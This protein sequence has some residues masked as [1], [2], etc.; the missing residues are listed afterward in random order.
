VTAAAA[1]CAVVLVRGDVG[2]SP[3]ALARLPAGSTLSA[4]LALALVVVLPGALAVVAGW[5]RSQ[6]TSDLAVLA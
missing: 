2:L 5:R 1:I 3:S 6:R 4:G